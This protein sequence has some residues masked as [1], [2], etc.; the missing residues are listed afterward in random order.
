M[1][2]FNKIIFN[3][4]QV[5]NMVDFYLKE[6]F[7]KDEKDIKVTSV[8]MINEENTLEIVIRGPDPVPGDPGTTS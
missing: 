2:G 6:F 3:K 8:R 7:L 5:Y 1:I 4:H